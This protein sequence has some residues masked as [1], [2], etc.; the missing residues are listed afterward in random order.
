MLATVDVWWAGPGDERAEHVDLLA[1]CEL[2]RR[3]G[4][5]RDVDRARFTVAAALLRTAAGAVVGRP[6]RDIEVDRTCP[7]C[8]GAHGRPRLPGTTLHASIAHAGDCVVVALTDVAPVGVDVEVVGSAQPALFSYVAAPDEL[9]ALD[10]QAFFVQWARKESVLKA[11]GEGLL[12]AMTSVAL[13]PPDEPPRLIRY[14]DGPLRAGDGAGA[15]M[16]DLAAG[17]GHVACV[18][19]L[20]VDGIVV[21][22]HDGTAL[23]TATGR[24]Y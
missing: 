1:D 3:R 9:F 24:A 16:A 5:R 4:Y 7:T 12:R 21:R 17:P 6:P 18:A 22:R 10:E 14:G 20:G 11:T 15:A 2:D 23:L 19:V 13:G 8:G